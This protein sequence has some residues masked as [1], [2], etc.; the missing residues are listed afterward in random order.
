MA[1]GQQGETVN[2]YIFGA[3]VLNPSSLSSRLVRYS[4]L[5]PCLNAFVDTRTPGSDT[6]E[7]FTIVGPGVSENPDQHVHI[8]EPHGFNIGGA[9]QPPGCLNSQHSHNTAEVFVVHSGQW[10]FLYGVN[11]TDASVNLSPGDTISI[12]TRMFRGFENTGDT[13]GFL[14][15]VLGGDDPGKVTWAPSVFEL[16]EQYGLVL[17]ECGRLVDVAAGDEVPAGAMRQQAPNDAEV[18]ALK[19]PTVNELAGCVALGASLQPNDESSLMTIVTGASVSEAAV[20]TPVDTPDGFPAGPI[21]GWWGHGFN[22][23]RITMDSG[24]ALSAHTRQ[25]AEVVFLHSGELTVATAA[26]EEVR[27]GPGDT[28]SLPVGMIRT[29]ANTSKETATAFVVRGGESP[30]APVAA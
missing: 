18:A 27:M 2:Y 1:D 20:I 30:H 29:W 13:T 6:K 5:K 22:L 9:R 11:G 26:G 21:K 12:P 3:S 8:P 19:T 28:L 15:A 7:N 16:A 17:L 14:F 25:E 23:R 24:S 10:R 4:D